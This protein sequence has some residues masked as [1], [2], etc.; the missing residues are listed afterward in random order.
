MNRAE[1]PGALQYIPANAVLFS[2]VVESW[3]STNT[4]NLWLGA[5]EPLP[6]TGVSTYEKPI[7]I[8]TLTH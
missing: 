5:L 7:K 2:H 4:R 6:E 1:G 3:N 8:I